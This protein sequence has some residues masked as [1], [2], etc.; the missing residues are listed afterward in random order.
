MN[1]LR[2]EV[3]KRR[4]GDDFRRYLSICVVSTLD[5]GAHGKH[6]YILEEMVMVM[7]IVMAMVAYN[8]Y[9]P[10]LMQQVTS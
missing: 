4:S 1:G 7:V 6:G 9:K 8:V 5:A 10:L 3:S 2:R